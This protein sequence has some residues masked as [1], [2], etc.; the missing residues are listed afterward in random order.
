MALGGVLFR[1]LILFDSIDFSWFHIL[2]T[3]KHSFQKEHRGEITFPNLRKV[4]C[5]HINY[6]VKL[7]TGTYAPLYPK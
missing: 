3:I 2:L 6:F 1:K 7:Y 4:F 5:L